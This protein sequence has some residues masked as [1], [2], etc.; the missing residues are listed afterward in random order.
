MNCFDFDKTIYKKDS[1][2][3]LLFYCIKRKP[4]LIFSLVYIIFLTILNKLKLLSIKSFKERYYK[5][6]NKFDDKEKLIEDFWDKEIKNINEWYLAEK[7][8]DDVIC[9][10]SPEFIIK[11][12]MTKI[13][14]KSI[15]IGTK[16]DINTLEI[17]GENLKGEQKRLVLEENGFQKFEKAYTD[18]LSDFPLY[19]MA[20]E[21]YFISH[22][23]AYIFGK[24]KLSFFQ[25]IKFI[26]KQM[27]IKHYVKNGLIFIP[28]I[29]SGLLTQGPNLIYLTTSIWGFVSFCLAASFVYIV[30]DLFDAK[31]DRNHSKKRKRPI[32]A[33]MI[34]PWEAISMLLFISAGISLIWIY[35]LNLNLWALIIITLYIIINLLYSFSLKKVPI[36]DVFVLAIC[37][38]IR[39][40]FG[41][42]IIGVGVS[43]WLYLTIICASLYMGYG[44]R[45]GEMK[46]E[47]GL[48]TRGVMQKY[49]YNFLDKNI[50]MC[51]TMCLVFYS[52]WA[53]DFRS[54]NSIEYFN[55]ILILLTI[56]MVI[57]ILM[58]YSLNIEKGGSGDPIDVLLKDYILLGFAILFVAM[59][60]VAIYVPIPM[61]I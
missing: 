21:K 59:I 2:I 28:L 56:P 9:S 8:D 46:N 37:Y 23:K 35:F 24:Q 27:R 31:K 54:I 34:K 3:S 50:Y 38:V 5:F 1:A 15:V 61:K 43:K 7:N 36:V 22:G 29:F 45:R 32:A 52:L 58:K 48:N 14:P 33:Y 30:N 44:K 10:A 40:Y 13:N 18:S 42:S 25:K 19:D 53:V 41:A 60:A 4:I 39:V 47:D 49:T 12:I 17:H 11:P 51:L 26:I 20:N 6:L 55:S 57:F 16:M